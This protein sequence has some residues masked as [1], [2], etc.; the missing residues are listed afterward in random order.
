MS[1]YSFPGSGASGKGFAGSALKE[2][3]GSDFAGELGFSFPSP[4]LVLA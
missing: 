2:S 4:W 1:W 3:A